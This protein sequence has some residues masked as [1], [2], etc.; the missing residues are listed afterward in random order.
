MELIGYSRG[1]YSS[2]FFYKPFRVLFDCGEG[3]ALTM[4]NLVFGVE[5]IFLSHSH[6]D[7]IYGLPA[8]LDSRGAARGDKEKPLEIYYPLGNRRIEELKAFC[9]GRFANRSYKIDW[10]PITPKMRVEL[11]NKVYVEC[12]VME[13]SKSFDTLGYKI[14]EERTRLKGEYKNEDIPALL[15]LGVLKSDI[16][17]NYKGILF[18]YCLD[19]FNFDFEEIR[20]AN[21]AILDSTFLKAEDRDANTHMT[22]NECVALSNALNIKHPI[23]AHISGRYSAKEIDSFKSKTS[24]TLVE[25]YRSF[26]LTF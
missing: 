11:S 12:F 4:R 22:F 21:I 20:N 17:E 14:V 15:K 24:V 1:L 18:A 5:K 9:E 16:T 3:C 7:H 26:S 2:W 23:L 10:I 8:F 6:G 19:S 13:H 25:N